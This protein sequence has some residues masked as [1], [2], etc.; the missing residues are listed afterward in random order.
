MKYLFVMYGAEDSWT[1]AERK[2]CVIESLGLC[3]Q[4]ATQGK[5]VSASPLQSVATAKTVRVRNGRTQV[6][7][8]PFAEAREVVGGYV[9]LD[10]ADM[11]EAVA[12]AGRFPTARKGTIEIRPLL[13]LDGLPPARPL[14][15]GSSDPSVSTYMLVC[16]DDESMWREAGPTAL[17]D[18]MKEATA[19]AHQLSDGGRYLLASPLQPAETAKCVRV[20]DGRRAVT[21]GPF[22]EAREVVGGFYLI[23]AESRDAA[24]DVAARH[25]GAR[26]AAVEVRALADLSGLKE[27]GPVH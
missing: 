15:A 5:Y 3:D 19:L 13:A 25:P 8:G 4:L 14:P 10:L 18:A 6:T 20:R 22:A 11:D 27:S 9:L 2:E 17:R 24:L 1:D 12:V 7:D 26:R 16:Y 23:L 21:D